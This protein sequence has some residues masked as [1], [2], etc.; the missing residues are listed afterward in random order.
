[1]SKSN[2]R[3]SRRRERAEKKQEQETV[4][5]LIHTMRHGGELKTREHSRSRN[6]TR[7]G[8][9]QTKN[10]RIDGGGLRVRWARFKQRLGTGS[11]LSESLLGGTG[12]SSSDSRS[13][14]RHAMGFAQ[15]GDDDGDDSAEVDEIVVDNALGTVTGGSQASEHGG[16]G[17]GRAPSGGES[18]GRPDL[19]GN[20][21]SHTTSFG[22]FDSHASLGVW[23]SNFVFS[24][25]RWTLWPLVLHFFTMRFG[26]DKT[27]YDYRRE[28]WWS[29]KTLGLYSSLFFVANWILVLAL[30]ARPFVLSD[31]IFFYGIGALISLPLPF[32]VIYDKPFKRPVLYQSYVAV[33]VWSWSLY[34]TIFMYVCDFYEKRGPAHCG[35]RDFIGTFL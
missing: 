5:E 7:S 22:T 19:T 31:I 12:A 6:G 4:L 18:N 32:L 21:K 25:F 27:E 26:E 23:E 15:P 11:A 16:T 13:L 2:L 35:Q 20:G 1:M 8:G 34:T 17:T 29:S 28:T 14:R 9:G 33:C 3:K 24:F 30:S 10:A